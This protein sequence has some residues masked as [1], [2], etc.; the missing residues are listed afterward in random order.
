MCTTTGSEASGPLYLGGIA[1]KTNSGATVSDCVTDVTVESVCTT[2][3]MGG[4][5]G[6]NGGTIQNC[7]AIPEMTGYQMGGLVG[8]NSG[9]I[10]NSYANPKFTY[11]GSYKYYGGLVGVNTGTVENC[12]ARVQGT[13]PATTYFGY[14]AG[15]NAGG[16][17]QYSYA[18]VATYVSSNGTAGTQT[19]LSTF[20]VTLATAYNYHV[21]DNQVDAVNTVNT[22][23]PTYDAHHLADYQLK[24]YLNKWVDKKNGSSSTYAGWT[25]PTTQT[26]NDDYPLLKL[27]SFNA[28][29]ATSGDASLNYGDINSH[30]TSF[31]NANQ[32]ICLYGSKSGVNTNVGIGTDAPLY[33]DEDAVLTQTG[34][35]QAY[36]G[37][38]L[39]NSACHNGANPSLASPGYTDNID[40]HFFSSALSDAPIGLEYPSGP[41]TYGVDAPQATFTL[42]NAANGYFPTNLDNYYGDWD[43]YAYYEPDYHWINLKRNSESHWHEDWPDINIPYLNESTFTAGKGYLVALKEEGY[44]QAYGTLNTHQTEDPLEVNLSYSPDISWTTRQGHNLLGNPY[45]SYLD[46]DAFAAANTGIWNGGLANASYIIM[47]EDQKDYVQYAYG[48]SENP[49]GA[50]RYLHPH[51]GFI[52]VAGKADLKAKFHDGMRSIT[53]S[54][55]FRSGD[56]PNYPLVNLFATDDN[57]NRDM[58]TV[59]LGRPDKGGALKQ[60]GLRTSKGSLSCHYEDEDYALVFTQPGLDAAN[61]RF[62]TDVDCAYTMTWNTQNGKF[63]YLHLIDNMT[64]TDI[65]CL[66]TE[67][68]KF[69]SRTS[70]YKSRFRLVFDYTG[71]E[72]N[73]EDVP[74]TSSGPS[75]FAF[76]MGNEVVVNGE[77]RL[78]MIDL[79][80]RIVKTQELHGNQNTVSIPSGTAG[81]YVLRLENGNGT[82]VQKIVVK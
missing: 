72:E 3:V 19:G 40:W 74:S 14:L 65:D 66:T 34:A 80:G 73:G 29:G 41:T 18:P 8:A 16:T 67:E 21:R 48:S 51:Q 60:S 37:V 39:D 26:I 9:N 42:D 15:N 79:L 1:K 69:N 78:E 62:A 76:Q 25:R 7:V 13:A 82:Q 44:L 23:A 32:A 17:L 71:V 30:L 59:E 45:Q 22:Y 54:A 27:T 38:T 53:G 68:Y 49:F 12:Y 61:I 77:G 10:Y 11:S 35:I 70:D 64:G 52:V 56:R 31:K 47:D 36:V 24:K 81:V 5:V 50:G 46:F 43:F 4:L 55:S 28:V 57:G 58:V 20:G 75:S 2:S 63:S 33:I 6:S